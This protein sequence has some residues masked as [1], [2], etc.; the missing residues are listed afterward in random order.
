MPN[1]QMAI[2][3]FSKMNTSLAEFA[4]QEHKKKY[5]YI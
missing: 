3:P 2:S 4:C 5:G 1:S